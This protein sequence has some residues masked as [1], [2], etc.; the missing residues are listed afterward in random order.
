MGL[1]WIP[2]GWDGSHWVG[3]DPIRLGSHGV[4]MDPMRLGTH[5]AG[6]DSMGLGWIP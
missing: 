1:G 3:M 4:G 6:M 2:L 5:G